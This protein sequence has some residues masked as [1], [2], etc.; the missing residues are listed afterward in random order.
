MLFVIVYINVISSCF[1]LSGV[2]LC[3]MLLIMSVSSLVGMFVYVFVMSHRL[4]MSLTELC[5]LKTID[6]INISFGVFVM[7]IANLYAGIFFKLT[8][9]HSRND[10]WVRKG[11]S[12]GLIHGSKKKNI[13]SKTNLYFN[14]TY[15]QM[16]VA[17][18]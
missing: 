10:Y 2:L 11:V 9:N 18:R 6:S 15:V 17:C 14:F 13:Y 16:I 1:F 5:T 3:K 12:L 4:W 8:T 7:R